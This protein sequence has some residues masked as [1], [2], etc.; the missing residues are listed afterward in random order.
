MGL[1]GHRPEIDEADGFDAAGLHFI[2]GTNTLGLGLTFAMH[3]AEACLPVAAVMLFLAAFVFVEV[4]QQL[5][6]LVV[7]AHGGEEVGLLQIEDLAHGLGL[8]VRALAE[9]GAGVL[10]VFL[11][12]EFQGEAADPGCRGLPIPTVGGGW[13]R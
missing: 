6:A 10:F 5:K 3:F 4:E 11:A 13:F 2:K 12:P 1:V 7:G 8:S 9:S